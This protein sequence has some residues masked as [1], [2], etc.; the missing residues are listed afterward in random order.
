MP[1]LSQTG[2][3]HSILAPAGGVIAKN[4]RKTS[5]SHPS[6][7][8]QKEKKANTSKHYGR[9]AWDMLSLL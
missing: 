8:I 4:T 9:L 2:L 7:P 6:I 5:L 3:A 1:A